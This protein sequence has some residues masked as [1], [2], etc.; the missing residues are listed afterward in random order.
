MKTGCFGGILERFSSGSGGERETVGIYT[1]GGLR[2]E[3]RQNLVRITLSLL[4]RYS[5]SFAPF[6]DYFVG[7]LMC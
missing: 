2:V 5:D 4:C 7:Y 3:S 6:S 1:E